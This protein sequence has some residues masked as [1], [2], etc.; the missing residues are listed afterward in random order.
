MF[1]R[2]KKLQ[3]LE[4]RAITA[5]E[6]AVRANNQ[7][8]VYRGRLKSHEEHFPYRKRELVDEML[9]FIR[10]RF[11]GAGDW[12]SEDIPHDHCE[13]EIRRLLSRLD[14]VSPAPVESPHVLADPAR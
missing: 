1:G 11:K 9:P 10:A 4:L 3:H 12:A 7:N 14:E 8:G 2:K 5:E 13:A 6:N